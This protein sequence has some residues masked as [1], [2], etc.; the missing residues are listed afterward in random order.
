MN[1]NEKYSKLIK[2]EAK[3]LGFESCGISKAEF[4]EEEAFN[5]EL[6]LKKGFQ[7]E[8]NYLENFFDKRLDPRLLVDDAKAVISLSF[9]YF[10]E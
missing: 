6:W 8:M 10:P 1:L 2:Q 3:R 5:L 9:N 4:L 7:G